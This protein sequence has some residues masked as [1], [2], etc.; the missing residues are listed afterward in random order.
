MKKFIL[1]LGCAIILCVASCG[2]DGDSV[3]D[4]GG[5]A[6]G[7]SD[8]TMDAYWVSSGEG[9]DGNPG[10]IDKPFKTIAK[11]LEVSQDGATYKDIHVVGGD[12]EEMNELTIT[13]G[14]GIYGGYGELTPENTRERDV[15]SN[16]TNVQIGE[17]S[18]CGIYIGKLLYGDLVTID[19]L[20]I[21]APGRTICIYGASA[22][23][24]NN[25]IH[26]TQSFGAWISF[27]EAISIGSSNK[28]ATIYV[29][30][31]NNVIT[32]DDIWVKTNGTY[33][34]GIEFFTEV[35]GASGSLNLKDNEITVG[36]GRQNSL[37][38]T[39]IELGASS[40]YFV[41]TG[42][43]IHT[44]A[45]GEASN[46][47]S[48]FDEN[49]VGGTATIDGNILIA[50]DIDQSVKTEYVQFGASATGIAAWGF[51]DSYII[52]NVIVSGENGDYSDGISLWYGNNFMVYNNTI[53]ARETA[54]ESTSKAIFLFEDSTIQAANNII[55]A[56]NGY[57]IYKSA[58]A[59]ILSLT[60]NLFCDS[61]LIVG[62]EGEDQFSYDSISDLLG[63]NYAD[64]SNLIGDPK[65][66]DAAN[67]DYHILSGS[68]AIDAGEDLSGLVD[69]D[70]D[71]EERPGGSAYDIGADEY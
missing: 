11:A 67:N 48:L 8:A 37:G 42:N 71:G 24:S 7:V 23:I 26:A 32:V 14:I 15:K 50:G 53:I 45:A 6:S 40:T 25:E 34:K 17:T 56:D 55:C 31:E 22:N 54:G 59:S 35:D 61:N 27:I 49:I 30:I 20:Y 62:L 66:A 51:G 68:D 70:I 47:I 21:T 69:D 65:F 44:G 63:T 41:A 19:G 4:A 64:D 2:G 13:S 38:V 1:V 28:D 29:N 33:S 16:K 39:V 10:T 18:R 5:V 46:P 9:S 57:G 60:S 52:N 36:D 43:T 12:Y 3:P 58:S